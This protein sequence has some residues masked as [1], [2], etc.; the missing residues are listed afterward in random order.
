MGVV[1]VFSR[2]ATGAVD[3]S[4]AFSCNSTNT[5]VLGTYVSKGGT[6]AGCSL[7]LS[8]SEAGGGS[9]SVLLPALSLSLPMRVWY[10]ISAT[11]S[12]ADGLLN[13]IS[14]AGGLSSVYQVNSK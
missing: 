11:V 2:A 9:V 8:G 14:G 7:V 6:P 10:P 13:R 1:E 3:A 4:S 5:A 12:I